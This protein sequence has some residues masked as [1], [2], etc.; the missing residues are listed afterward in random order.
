MLDTGLARCTRPLSE[1][2]MNS[3][4]LFMEYDTNADQVISQDEI[5]LLNNDLI[6]AG[7]ATV[8]QIG[9]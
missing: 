4:A 6:A 9:R 1:T 5:T 3:A 7:Q 2:V 8:P